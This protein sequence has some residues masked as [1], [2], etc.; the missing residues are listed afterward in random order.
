MLD[1]SDGQGRN[2]RC[3]VFVHGGVGA[4]LQSQCCSLLCCRLLDPGQHWT[5]R[6]NGSAMPIPSKPAKKISYQRHRY[7]PTATVTKERGPVN[8]KGIP[9]V[10]GFLESLQQVA[11]SSRVFTLTTPQA[12]VVPAATVPQD[13]TVLH[14]SPTATLDIT[15]EAPLSAYTSRLLNS[16]GFKNENVG[17]LAADVVDKFMIT[18]AEARRIECSTRTQANNPLWHQHRKGRVTAS[19]FKDVCRSK[20]VRC[21]TLFNKIMS[22]RPL[23]V[24]AV[25]YGVANEPVAKE[26]LLEHLQTTHTNARIEACGLMVHPNYPLLGCSP[27]GIFL[28]DCHDP[29]LVEVKCLFSLRD[30]SPQDLVAEGQKRK[31]F[32]LTANGTLKESH[33]YYYQ[34]QAQLHLNLDNIKKMLLLPSCR[35]RRAPGSSRKRR[36]FYGNAQ[37]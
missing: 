26:R 9:D 24:P 18:E 35:G 20:R 2:R 32:C 30:C 36:K 28:C 31:G 23:N 15:L 19:I 16:K 34:V 7:G 12:G 11:P 22:L 4:G 37:R 27:D 14:N 29:A 10:K 1:C 6:S 5:S 8:L 33:A 25:L 21:T 17:A 3:Q 13:A